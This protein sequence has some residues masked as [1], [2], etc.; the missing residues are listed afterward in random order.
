MKIGLILSKVPGYSE[1]FLV[2]KIKGLQEAGHSV[3]LFSNAKGNSR[4]FAGAKVV[5]S[6]QKGTGVR[7]NLH[8]LKVLMILIRR[9][10]RMLA[11]HRILAGEGYSLSERNRLLLINAHILPYYL[12]WLHFGFATLMLEKEFTAKAMSA[13]MGVSLRGYDINVYPL[14]HKA[15]YKL[16]WRQINKV[17]SISTA[18]YKSAI[19]QGLPETVKWTLITPAIDYIFFQRAQ[20]KDSNTDVIQLLTVG[21]LAWI[22][23]LEYGL[24]A[25]ALLK[26]EGIRFKYTIVGD[27]DLYERLKFAIYQYELDDQVELVGKKTPEETVK[28]YQSSDIYLQPSLDEGFCNAVIEAQACGCLCIVSDTGGLKENIIDNKTGWLVPARVPEALFRK[29]VEVNALSDMQKEIIRQQARQHVET[30]FNLADQVT[31]FTRFFENADS[32]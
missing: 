29:I 20:R 5:S 26:N 3:L 28:Y 16:A 21:R 25:L 19:Q 12:D 11:F 32:I 8:N 30:N 1:T 2:N 7:G 23:G 15:C 22:K 4:V 24:A 6:I 27:G 13:K 18:L 9:P 31:L 14:K 10:G 17:H